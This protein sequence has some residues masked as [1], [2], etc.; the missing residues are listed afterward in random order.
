MLNI[1]THKYIMNVTFESLCY[2]F[3]IRISGVIRMSSLLQ[4]YRKLP[5]EIYILFFARIVNSIGSFVFPLLTLILTEKVG[6]AADEA[7]EYAMLMT[8]AQGL[9]MVAGGKL[10]DVLG[11]KKLII[12]CNILGAACYT[13]CGFIEPSETMVNLIIAASSIYSLS[14]PALEAVTM[15]VSTPSNRKA[16]FGLLYM[17][18]NLGYAVEP[19]IAGLLFEKNL[20]LL[21]V[22]DA[23]TTL[24]STLLI[25]FFLKETLPQK[26]DAAQAS[27]KY[28]EGSVFSVLWQRKKLLTYALVLFLFEFAYIQWG[29]ELPLQTEALFEN[30]AFVYTTLTSFNAILVIALTPLITLLLQKW[31]PLRGMALAGLLFMLSFGMLIFFKQL[32]AFYIMIFV[33]TVG[34][35]FSTIDSKTYLANNTPSSHRGRL[36]SAIQFAGGASRL[37][38]PLLIG[39]IIVNQGMDLGWLVIASAAGLGAA[40]VFSLSFFEARSAKKSAP[41]AETAES[42]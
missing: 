24:L 20:P 6:L 1:L 15:D 13:A 22:G 14:F 7:G 38:S 18:L 17:G 4:K 8:A 40:A 42:A 23:A 11:R 41:A 9:A 12:G 32:E 26:K 25:A 35:I 30:G 34:E 10:T 27:E 16:A 2:C 33:M 3:I 29:F 37:V 28:S 36:N 19:L 21:F 31:K 5:R 39:S